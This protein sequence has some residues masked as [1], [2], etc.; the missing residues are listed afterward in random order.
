M[1]TVRSPTLLVNGPWRIPE[2]TQ[3]VVGMLP[4]SPQEIGRHK[5]STMATHAGRWRGVGMECFN[6]LDQGVIYGA[7]GGA[8]VGI[9]RALLAPC[10]CADLVGA[11]QQLHDR[12]QPLLPSNLFHV[13]Q[14][15]QP[16]GMA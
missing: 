16:V 15:G 7:Q 2:E 13:D 9:E 4:A 5:I 10:R 1:R 14:F 11:K 8:I 3:D 6:F 12:L